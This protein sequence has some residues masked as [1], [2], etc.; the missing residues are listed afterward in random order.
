MDI[1]EWLAEYSR[2]SVV[3][4]IMLEVAIYVMGG[5]GEMEII[6]I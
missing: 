3:L 6:M 4:S 1:W 2:F 5:Y